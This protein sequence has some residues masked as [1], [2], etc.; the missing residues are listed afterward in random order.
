MGLKVAP[1]LT[2]IFHLFLWAVFCYPTVA[3]PLSYEWP[4]IETLGDNYRAYL[5]FSP[6]GSR[7]VSVAPSFAPLSARIGVVTLRVR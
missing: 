2:I 3:A 4:N 7:G 6:F 5:F 1:F